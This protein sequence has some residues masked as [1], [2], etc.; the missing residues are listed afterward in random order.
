MPIWAQVTVLGLILAM[1]AIGYGV[2]EFARFWIR[3][4]P[5]SKKTFRIVVAHVTYL[6]LMAA[7]FLVAGISMFDVFGWVG[8]SI[9]TDSFP[10]ILGLGVVLLAL[11]LVDGPTLLTRPEWTKARRRRI[12]RLPPVGAYALN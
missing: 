3:E 12:V 8:A 5:G 4:W 2:G 10:P 1:I 9:Q 11:G 7:A 6:P